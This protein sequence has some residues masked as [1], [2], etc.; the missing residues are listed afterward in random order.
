MPGHRRRAALPLP[1]RR[2][3]RARAGPSLRSAGAADRS[4]LPRRWPATSCRPTTASSAR[5]SAWWST[6]SSIGRATATCGAV[7]RRRSSTRCTSAASR[8]RRPAAWSIRARTCGV[9]EKIPYLKS[10]GVTAVELMPVHEFPIR[11]LPGPGAAAAELLGLR[12]DGASSRRIAAT[13]S[14]GEPGCQV[15]EFKE[16]VRAL[17]QAGHRSD[18]RRGLQPHGRRQRARARRSAS[19]AWRTASTTCSRTA[20]ST[21]ATTPAAATRSTAI[22]RS[23]AR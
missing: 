13:R 6:T 16:M 19:R 7:C 12:S 20:G 23:S 8:D 1:G 15:R 11:R 10:L 14:A 22:T 5:R 21:T 3:V 9:I 2:A 4:L 17:H 18:P